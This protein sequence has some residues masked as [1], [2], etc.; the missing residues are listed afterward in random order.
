MLSVDELRF[1]AGDLKEKADALNRAAARL[2]KLADKQ[3]EDERERKI[4]S[5]IMVLL[6]ERIW[7][8]FYPEWAKNEVE[9][10]HKPTEDNIDQYMH[11]DLIVIL[12]DKA[13]S[14]AEAEIYIR[15]QI[16]W[17]MFSDQIYE[18][19][20]WSDVIT[21]TAIRRNFGEA[22]KM[23]KKGSELSSKLNYAFGNDDLKELMKLH[24]ANRFRKKIEDLLTDCNF[25]YESGLLHE[26]KYAELEKELERE[27]E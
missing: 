18:R 23:V 12:T 1:E 9:S 8:H 24:K 22:L 16:D 2:F 26:K 15:K 10:D 3:E 6:M 20:N 19:I 7:H 13:F 25:H 11:A 27:E 17:I 14:E 5:Q 21:Q 4:V